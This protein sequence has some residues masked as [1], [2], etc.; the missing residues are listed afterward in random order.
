VFEYRMTNFGINGSLTFSR[1]ER[2][3]K[4]ETNKYLVLEMF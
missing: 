3:G 1:F 4:R 2:F